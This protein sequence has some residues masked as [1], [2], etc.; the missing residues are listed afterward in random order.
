MRYIIK[1]ASILLTIYV[2]VKVIDVT[3]ENERMKNQIEILENKLDMC[4]DKT[5][6]V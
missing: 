2:L 4:E 3:N 1:L 5:E 6:V